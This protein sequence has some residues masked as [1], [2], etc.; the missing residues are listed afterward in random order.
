MAETPTTDRPV[1]L[2]EAV[3]IAI[4]LQQNEQ[5]IAAG[6]LYRQILEV[7]P[8]YADALHFYGVL[9]HQE[10]NSEKAVELIERSLQL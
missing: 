4:Q 3:G 9:S 6:D 2:E 7:A 5:W 10:G 1:S 8:D